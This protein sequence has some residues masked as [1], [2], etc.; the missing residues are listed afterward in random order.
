MKGV[1]FWFNFHNFNK[2]SG[3]KNNKKTQGA[4]IQQKTE[5]N[6]EESHFSFEL[7]LL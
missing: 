3:K 1:I 7:K 4:Q 6:Q 5:H 2:A